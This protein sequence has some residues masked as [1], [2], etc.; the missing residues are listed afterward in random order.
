MYWHPR[1]WTIG[2]WLAIAYITLFLGSV[3]AGFV[4]HAGHPD[5]IILGYLLAFIIAVIIL[6]FFRGQPPHSTE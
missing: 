4:Y 3:V 6:P 1:D 2:A 5:G